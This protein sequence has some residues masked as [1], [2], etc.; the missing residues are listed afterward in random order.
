MKKENLIPYSGKYSS[1][2]YLHKFFLQFAIYTLTTYYENYYYYYK[3]YTITTTNTSTNTNTN[4]SVPS[5]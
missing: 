3:I 2:R 1:I 5:D 4:I